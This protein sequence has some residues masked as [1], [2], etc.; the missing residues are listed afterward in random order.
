MSDCGVVCFPFL[1]PPIFCR[2]YNPVPGIP[3]LRYAPCFQRL[4]LAPGTPSVVLIPDL[5]KFRYTPGNS[6]AFLLNLIGSYFLH[7]IQREHMRWADR[8]GGLD[9]I[10]IV[11]EH[12]SESNNIIYLNFSG[13]SAIALI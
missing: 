8:M 1:P 9:R 12:F 4:T 10:C 7:C 11:K 5:L 3:V 2:S 13:I 6:L